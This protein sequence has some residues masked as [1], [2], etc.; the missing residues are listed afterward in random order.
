MLNSFIIQCFIS[1]AGLKRFELLKRM[2]Q[3]SLIP[4]FLSYLC[5]CFQCKVLIIHISVYVCLLG[6]DFPERRDESVCFFHLTLLFDANP[7][8]MVKKFD[9]MGNLFKIHVALSSCDGGEWW[10][11]NTSAC[12]STAS[13]AHPFRNFVYDIQWKWKGGFAAI[14]L[15]AENKRNFY[16]ETFTV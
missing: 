9:A 7:Y 14:L 13:F 8:E 10:N 3:E 15:L 16:H 6:R 12:S 5:L 11:L 2:L 4:S 1:C